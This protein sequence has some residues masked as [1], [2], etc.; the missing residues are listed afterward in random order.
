VLSITLRFPLGVYHAQAQSDFSLAEWPPHPVRLIAALV[1]AAHGGPADDV[2]AARAAIDR[3]ARAGAPLIVAPRKAGNAIADDGEHTVAQLRGASRWAPR[4]H[5]LSELKKGISPR[6]LGRGRAEVHK[7]GV[8]I[9]D[10]PVTFTWPDLELGVAD[11][12]RLRRAADDVTFVGTSR[13][14]VLASVTTTADTRQAPFAAWR[15]IAG[16]EAVAATEPVP[17]RVPDA[18]TIAQLDTWHARRS[19]PVLR[20]GAPTKAPLV[21][22]PRLGSVVEYSHDRDP[23]TLPVLDPRHWGDMLVLSLSGATVPKAPASFALARAMRKALLDTYADPGQEGEAPPILRGRR[24]E[25]HAAFVPLSFV[26]APAHGSVAAEH[27]DGHVLGIAV[28]LPH[29][30][31]VS[32]LDTQRDAVIS[33]A[34]IDAGTRVGGLLSL[35]GGARVLVPG[36]GA[37]EL[38]SP[39]GRP[40]ATLQ[41]SRYRRASA[42]WT[43][44]TPLVHSRYRTRKDAAAL[45]DQVA[46]ECRDVGLPAP[47]EVSVRRTARLR[48]APNHIS[49]K[50]LPASWTGP[51]KGPQAHLDLSFERPIEGP[52]LLG[53]ARHFGL[54]LCLPVDPA[55]LNR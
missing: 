21:V 41:E 55:H 54:G 22:A 34:P 43:T 47:A 30:S 42:Y 27:A 14:P 6:D 19:A 10:L 20:S 52:V 38:T 11:E 13:S 12:E 18:G 1:A 51:L 17:V 8:A 46:A 40:R 9:G 26:A 45:Y 53:R 23:H 31:R 5:E 33:G 15:P 44:I 32:D 49:A 25:P 24:G 3:V 50:G 48:G 4:N 28:L 16:R 29:P 35:I 2:D 36:V 7:V 37:V 39:T